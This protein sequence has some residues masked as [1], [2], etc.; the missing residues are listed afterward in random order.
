MNFSHV[1]LAFS[2]YIG[3]PYTLFDVK[4]YRREKPLTI[5]IPRQ[6]RNTH[7]RRP[8]NLLSELTLLWINYE[9]KKA[10]NT[11][12]TYDLNILKPTS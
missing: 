6:G 7:I 3:L 5:L 11:D 8:V 4:E 12:N 9:T 10:L 1:S 2:L